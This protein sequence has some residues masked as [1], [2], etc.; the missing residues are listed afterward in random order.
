MSLLAL[1]LE[2]FFTEG[3]I[4]QRRAS[5]HR[6]ASYR[7]AF[8]LLLAF[9]HQRTGRQPSQLRFEDLDAPLISAFLEHLEHGIT[10][11]AE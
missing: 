3:L 11:R 9:A 8:A 10:V 2:A 4:G 1:T 5:P 7:D 6:I